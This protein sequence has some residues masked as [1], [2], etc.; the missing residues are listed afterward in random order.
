[1]PISEAELVFDAVLPYDQFTLPVEKGELTAVSI[2]QTPGQAGPNFAYP[3]AFY[4]AIYLAD[5]NLTV[6]IPMV[7]L[8]EGRLGSHTAVTWHGRIKMEPSSVLVALVAGY[9]ATSFTLRAFKEL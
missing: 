5:T 6:P 2:M 4:A 8:A 7:L 1:M 3:A 9:Q